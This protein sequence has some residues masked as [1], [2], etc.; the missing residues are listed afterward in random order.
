MNVPRIPPV[1]VL[2]AC[3]GALLFLST[4]LSLPAADLDLTPVGQWPS[5]PTGPVNAVVVQDDLA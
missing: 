3:L 1:P 2:G 5:H 4:C